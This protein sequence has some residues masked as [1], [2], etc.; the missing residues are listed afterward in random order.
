[1]PY[2]DDFTHTN[3]DASRCVVCGHRDYTDDAGIC[4]ECEWSINAVDRKLAGKTPAE[5]VNIFLTR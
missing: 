3:M 4:G 2:T 1:M 5:Q